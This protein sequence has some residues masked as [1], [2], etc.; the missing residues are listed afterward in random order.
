[1]AELDDLNSR[2]QDSFNRIKQRMQLHLQYKQVKEAK[3]LMEEDFQKM[4]QSGRPID[5]IPL[6]NKLQ[7]IAETNEFVDST[8]DFIESLKLPNELSLAIALIVSGYKTNKTEDYR[9]AI[10]SLENYIPKEYRE[11][12]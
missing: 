8:F 12:K 4:Q 5:S 9:K 2:A 1:M 3:N 6:E 7:E 11:E 10:D